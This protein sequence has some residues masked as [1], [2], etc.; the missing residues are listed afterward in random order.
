MLD[1]M[2]LLLDSLREAEE[3][4]FVDVVSDALASTER[5]N[6]FLVSN[7]LWG[8]AGSIADQAGCKGDRNDARRRIEHALIELGIA[9]IEAGVTNPRTDMWVNTFKEWREDG[10]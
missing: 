5:A 6:L 4:A 9:Q 8:G 3:Y 7:D 1:K 10:I 2:Q